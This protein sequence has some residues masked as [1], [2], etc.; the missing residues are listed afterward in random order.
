MRKKKNKNNIKLINGII[1]F[2]IICLI[3]SLI[4]MLMN[5]KKVENHITDISYSE[6]LDVINSDEYNVILLTTS[7]CSHC[8]DYKPY[9]NYVCD[10]NN[11]LVYNLDI[12]KLSYD[13]YIEIHDKYTATQD[14]YLENGSPSILTPTTIITKNNEEIYSISGNLGYSG[15]LDLLKENGVIKK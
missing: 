9:V 10:D 14:K 7:T 3:I 4:I 11:L 2:G 5:N 13:E 12:S 1:I 8:K 15:F 6:Y